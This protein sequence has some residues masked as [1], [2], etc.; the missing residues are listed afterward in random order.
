MKISYLSL[1][2]IVI[3]TSR[4][5]TAQS[6]DQA[7]MPPNAI[8]RS[9]A[10]EWEAFARSQQMMPQRLPLGNE[11]IM[12]PNARVYRGNGN[13]M[14]VRPVAFHHAVQPAEPIVTPPPQAL[15]VSELS[16]TDLEEMAL[17]RNPAVAA[18]AARVDAA[19][20]QWTQVGLLPNPVIG[21]SSEEIGDSGTSGKQGGFIGQKLV[22]AG[23][24]RLNRAVAEQQIELAEQQWTAW[25][26]RV[27]TDVRVGFYAVLIAQ[28]RLEITSE[29]LKTSEAALHS[30][31]ALVDAE[32]T[33]RVDVLQAQVEND[34]IKIRLQKA[35]NTHVAAWRQL[36]AVLGS[37]GMHLQRLTGD[38][39]AARRDIVW[40]D[41]LTR[42]LRESPEIAA[43][44]A[45]LE[46][47]RWALDRAR[48]GRIPNVNLQAVVQ[49][50]N[51]TGDTVTGVQVG[52]P[53]P[54]FD[55]NQGGIVKA[56]AEVRSAERQIE[57][58]ELELQRRL[59]IVYQRYANSRFE[60]DKYSR[61]IRPRAQETL[62]L[63]T[64]SYKAGETG[65]LTLLTAQRTYFQTNLSYVEALR[66]MWQA[67]L[68]IEGLLL[69]GSLTGNAT[70]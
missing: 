45:E 17:Q 58:V 53:F 40:Q 10:A 50:D 31:T 20:G 47:A 9:A 1:I 54:I 37:P 57:R 24:L 30:A 2:A 39:D 36:T 13:S 44:Y 69:D 51:A 70:Q 49:K 23:K 68:Q 29:L 33:S 16:L 35:Q 66:N 19:R 41:A 7:I 5:R 21:Y 62:D 4:C 48:A 43:A 60:V 25:R 61:D 42:L 56:A 46:R 22:T 52:M 3:I 67:S 59:A 15:P 18:A 63:V 26:Q 55:R 64:E 34:S 38:V 65:Y 32:E 12:A 28:R 27:L 6:Q 11:N 8:G 14:T